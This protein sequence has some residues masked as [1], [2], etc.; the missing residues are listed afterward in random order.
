[1]WNAEKG[2]N[3]SSAP[4]LDTHQPSLSDQAFS[5]KGVLAWSPLEGWTF[6]ASA[7]IA[8]RFP[9][10]SELY[11]AVTTGTVLS[12]PNP[13]LKP[14]HALSSELSAEKDWSGGSLRLSLFDERIRNALV[15]QSAPLN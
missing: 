10:V 3:F 1:W 8:N 12:V 6:K 13:N 2:L 11:Q 14:E 9:T 15:S 7:A 4:A 5:P